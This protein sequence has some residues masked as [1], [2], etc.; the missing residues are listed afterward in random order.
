MQKKKYHIIPPHHFQCSFFFLIFCPFPTCKILNFLFLLNWQRIMCKRDISRLSNNVLKG[1][2][3]NNVKSHLVI[4]WLYSRY[5]HII[6]LYSKCCNIKNRFRLCLQLYFAFQELFTCATNICLYY[7]AKYIIIFY[8]CM[9]V[10]HPEI[11]KL[12]G[13]STSSSDPSSTISI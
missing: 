13:S 8:V 6:P 12:L 5:T 11:F 2:L 9:Y 3:Y 1:R 10:V 7:R 4:L